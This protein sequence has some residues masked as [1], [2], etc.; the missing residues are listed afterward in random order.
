MEKIVT[1]HHSIAEYAV[2]GIDDDFKEKT[3]L[4]LVVNRFRLENDINIFC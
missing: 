3:S 4:A 1:S 2:I